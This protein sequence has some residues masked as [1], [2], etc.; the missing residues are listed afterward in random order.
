MALLRVGQDGP[1]GQTTKTW[2]RRAECLRAAELK[3]PRTSK[4]RTAGP[5]ELL[6][7]A[8]RGPVLR[9]ME[10]IRLFGTKTGRVTKVDTL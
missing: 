7:L 8:Q 2:D 1:S 3:R 4:A 10:Y 9:Q 5:A 6:Y